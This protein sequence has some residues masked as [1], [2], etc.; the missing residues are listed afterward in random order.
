M[1]FPGPDW[2]KTV[3]ADAN[4]Q[5]FDLE[6]RAQFEGTILRWIEVLVEWKVGSELF[7]AEG[8]R[9]IRNGLS[10]FTFGL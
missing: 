9:Y 6:E 8:G 4:C 10:I 1:D 7:V 2:G 5:V 3:V